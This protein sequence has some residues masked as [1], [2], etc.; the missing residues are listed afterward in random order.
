MKKKMS[1]SPDYF[2]SEGKSEGVLLMLI[3]LSMKEKAA[4]GSTLHFLKK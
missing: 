4:R 2:L 1:G 3:T